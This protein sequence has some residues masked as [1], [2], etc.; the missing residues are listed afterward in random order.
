[1]RE[2]FRSYGSIVPCLCCCF[3]PGGG[4]IYVVHLLTLLQPVLVDLARGVGRNLE[5]LPA[6]SWCFPSPR[7]YTAEWTWECGRGQETEVPTQRDT[8][9]KY[10][11]NASLTYN[12]YKYL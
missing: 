11:L 10:K 6:T 7:L 8:C 3:S 9:I 5:I 1:M 4:L 12:P 2:P